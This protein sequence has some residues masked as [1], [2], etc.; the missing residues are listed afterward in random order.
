MTLF[1]SAVKLTPAG[2]NLWAGVADPDYA[3]PG[4]RFGGWT[5]ATL[6]KAAMSEPGERGDPLS[7]TVLFTDAV[8]DG[9][10]LISTRVL[11]VGARL[12]FLRAELSQGDKVCAHAQITFGVRRASAG[13]TDA[14]MPAMP[15]PNDPSLIPFSPPT[16]FGE[17]LEARW[18]TPPMAVNAPSSARSL[19]WS[20][21]KWGFGM[22]HLLLA[23]LADYA[24]PRVTLKRGAFL[25][26]S[27]VSM[28]VYFHA[29]PEEMASVGDD[30]V[31]S[32]VDCRRCEG[33]YY[34]HQLKLWSRSGALLATSEQIAA[35][36][37]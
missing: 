21:H 37:G 18:A 20:R 7:M 26:S 28:N 9:S 6:L 14:A 10:I 32:E 3:H 24:P 27:T 31:V 16:R 23:L 36:R 17:Q 1:S 30:W 13:F 8:N 22:D 29:T 25:M 35:F 15:P 19:F 33:G 2:E 11:R 5:A 34:D 12:Q 4:G